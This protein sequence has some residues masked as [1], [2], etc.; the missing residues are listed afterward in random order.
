MKKKSKSVT[1]P[2]MLNISQVAELL[3]CSQRHCW[4]MAKEGLMPQ[5]LAMGGTKRWSV[6]QIEAW[7]KDGCKPVRKEAQK[8]LKK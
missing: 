4:R 1:Q 6:K 5:A 8:C 7:I 2:L 3:N